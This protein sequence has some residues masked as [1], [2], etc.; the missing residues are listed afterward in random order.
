MHIYYG[1][2]NT[3]GS[4]SSSTTG[5][6]S[7]SVSDNGG[8]KTLVDGDLYVQIALLDA[9]KMN[10]ARPP[11]VWQMVHNRH[12]TKE[13]NP[14]ENIKKLHVTLYGY[15]IPAVPSQDGIK[16]FGLFFQDKLSK[17]G[18]VS[19]VADGSWASNNGIQPGFVLKSWKDFS[20][21]IT[22]GKGT[23]P[24]GC[25]KYIIT[26]LKF[27]KVKVKSKDSGGHYEIDIH[28]FFFISEEQLK[29]Y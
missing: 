8:S 16:T 1:N 26:E 24:R 22:V 20:K 5:H 18:F 13:F 4:G 3:W 29:N 17:S 6:S 25:D 11:V 14:I 23:E 15:P 19:D 27:D 7:T 2:Y 12:F 21:K 28:D 10:G 9:Q